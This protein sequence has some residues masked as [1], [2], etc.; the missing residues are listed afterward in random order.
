MRGT[1]LLAVALVAVTS[2][3]CLRATALGA[4]ALPLPSSAVILASA[5]SRAP[6]LSC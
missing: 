3:G 2:G 1:S 4:P 5:L 6:A